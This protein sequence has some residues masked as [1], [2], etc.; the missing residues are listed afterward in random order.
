MYVKQVVTLNPP[1]SILN[2][3]IFFIGG[4]II[5]GKVVF[6]QDVVLVDAPNASMLAKAGNTTPYYPT[7][8]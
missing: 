7:D 3:D 1:Q 2:A 5:R 8:S 4:E 6:Y